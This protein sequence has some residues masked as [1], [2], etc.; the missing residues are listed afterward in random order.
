MENFNDEHDGALISLEDVIELGICP[1]PSELM[2]E[3]EQ[4]G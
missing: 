4:H 1:V 3:E 2:N